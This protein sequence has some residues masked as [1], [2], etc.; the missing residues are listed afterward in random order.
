MAGRNLASMGTPGASEARS[1]WRPP[2]PASRRTVFK[3]PPRLTAPCLSVSATGP[4]RTRLPGP[5]VFPSE[6]QQPMETMMSDERVIP[7]FLGPERAGQP[8]DF[9]S[10]SP[11]TLVRVACDGWAVAPS[12][13]QGSNGTTRISA[14]P[15]RRRERAR[16][17]WEGSPVGRRDGKAADNRVATRK[18]R[19]DR[20]GVLAAHQRRVPT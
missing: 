6:C 17:S 9:A 1:S 3:P 7:V 15:G 4:G 11:L 18:R 20:Q 13:W 8:R 14:C 12:V 5:A 19:A 2:L 16:W 10:R